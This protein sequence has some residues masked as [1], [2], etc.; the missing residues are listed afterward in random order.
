MSLYSHLAWV[1]GILVT[2]TGTFGAGLQCT[3]RCLKLG[4]ACAAG[5]GFYERQPDAMLP[6]W[7]HVSAAEE[8]ADMH[9]YAVKHLLLKDFPDIKLFREDESQNVLCPAM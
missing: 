7:S 3:K 6:E 9:D 1:Q 8:D 2:G 5:H 4:V